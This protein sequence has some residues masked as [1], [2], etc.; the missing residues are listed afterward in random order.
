[1]LTLD[2]TTSAAFSLIMDTP[3]ILID[4]SSVNVTKNGTSIVA[5]TGI[6]DVEA[7]AAIKTHAD[8]KDCFIQFG[9]GTPFSTSVGFEFDGTGDGWGKIVLLGSLTS[10]GSY[11]LSP[12]CVVYISNGVTLE[13]RAAISN[14]S[15][16]TS[17][18]VI[19]NAGTGTLTI[20]GGSVTSSAGHAVYN[21]TLGALTVSGGTISSSNSLSSAVF[22]STSGALTISGGT[23]SSS[24][25]AV[26]NNTN[27]RLI[28]SGGT[29]T[30][31]GSVQTL[32]NGFGEVTISGGRVE[33]TANRAISMSS[34]N[35]KITIS[36]NAVITSGGGTDL[37]TIWL[38]SEDT[39][40]TMTGG[41]VRQTGTANNSTA[42]FVDATGVMVN[43]TG[44]TVST[45]AANGNF[46]V[47]NRWANPAANVVVASACIA[48]G[49]NC[50]NVTFTP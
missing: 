33:S 1:M 5:A 2:G 34:A 35:G 24:N 30:G 37:P 32:Y 26:F 20:S 27:G 28:I 3:Y 8:K 10:T 23:L 21:S 22:N 7:I 15:T 40:L 39:E 41:E 19:Y 46:A 16:D 38:R 50:Q 48:P 45:A 17:R 6:G 9:T 13:S 43:I 14:T 47:E 44:G 12:S 31:T 11:T 29:L 4:G 18:Y 42:I 25:A 49:N 36:G